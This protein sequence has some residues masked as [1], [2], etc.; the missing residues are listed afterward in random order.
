MKNALA[1]GMAGVVLSVS[2]RGEVLFEQAPFRNEVA[3]LT[4]IAPG[5][6]IADDFR[7]STDV[8]VT[9]VNWFGFY[10]GDPA[11]PHR[12]RIAFHSDA[13]G[14][15]TDPA[16]VEFTATPTTTFAFRPSPDLPPVSSFSAVIPRTIFRADEQSWVSIVDLDDGPQFRWQES[17]LDRGVGLWG[18]RQ[19]DEEA[20]TV[21]N[22]GNLAC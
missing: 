3:G 10:I 19:S 2:V 15:L 17:A 8:A 7:A 12:F 16:V 1:F 4:S 11:Q 5:Q 13:G 6:Q 21:V 22:G 18:T 9:T 20:W 14:I